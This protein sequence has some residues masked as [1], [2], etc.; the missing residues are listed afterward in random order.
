MKLVIFVLAGSLAGCAPIAL[1]AGGVAISA[2]GFAIVVHQGSRAGGAGARPETA[3]STTP[4]LAPST[5]MA[6]PS[7]APKIVIPATGGTPVLATPVGG[8]VYISA[9]T[10]RPIIGVPV[11]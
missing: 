11:N 5:T 1:F 10:G 8:G 9:T 7:M 3:A 4:L 2:G 6:T